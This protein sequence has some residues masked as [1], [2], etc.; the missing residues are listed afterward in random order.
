MAT[1]HVS[2]VAVLIRSCNP[3]INATEIAWILRNTAINFRDVPADPVPND[4]YGFGLIDAAA[5]VR[6]ACPW[7]IPFIPLPKT[8]FRDEHTPVTT[9]FRDD[10]G[11]SKFRDDN[12]PLPFPP[13]LP[14]SSA[15]R[16]WGA[17]PFVLAT[18]HHST[19]WQQSYPEAHRAEMEAA[20]VE[21]EAAI[22]QMDEARQ[23]GELKEADLQQ[24]EA[25]H[26]EY[27]ALLAEYQQWFRP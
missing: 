25:I 15:A 1:P 18:P 23:R 11:K 12:T 20:L 21:Y 14:W 16:L 2:G 5:A 3:S 19:A 10:G 6:R 24:L 17:A 26:Q 27:Q 8:K 13:V 9:K 4:R 7:S 22:V